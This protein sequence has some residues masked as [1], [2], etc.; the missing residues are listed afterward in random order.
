[1]W[2]DVQGFP[3]CTIF[4]FPLDIMHFFP[5]SP[6]FIHINSTSSSGTAWRAKSLA[7]C[8]TRSCDYMRVCPQV[9][10]KEY[11][12]PQ[13]PRCKEMGKH[14][15][16]HLQTKK[17]RN[18]KREKSTTKHTKSPTIN[19]H[20]NKNPT[21]KRDKTRKNNKKKLTKEQT[22]TQKKA[23]K[24]TSMMISSRRDTQPR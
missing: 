22:K 16:A 8:A 10:G 7:S 19:R 6:T 15:Q 12:F 18:T 13:Q 20:I 4:S 17:E 3:A 21:D 11:F 9:S 5:T 1:M 24:Q 2:M 23:K 14:K